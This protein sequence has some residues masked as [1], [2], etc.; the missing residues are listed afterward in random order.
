LK[1][2]IVAFV[3]SVL[4]AAVAGVIADV[5]EAAVFDGAPIDLRIFFDPFLIAVFTYLIAI[6]T[7]ALGILGIPLTIALSNRQLERS[8]SYPVFGIAIGAVV[9]VLWLSPFMHAADFKSDTFGQLLLI[10][11]SSGCAAGFVWWHM[12]RKWP[13]LVE[14]R[15]A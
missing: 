6:S 2:T 15:G 4:S 7:L 10:G 13:S 8:W 9:T 11:G 1:R 12:Y 14:G 5:I 3:L